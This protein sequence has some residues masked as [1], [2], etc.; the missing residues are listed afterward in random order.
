M[1]KCIKL[2]KLISV[3]TLFSL[4]GAMLFAAPKIRITLASFAPENTVWGRSLNQLA[5]DWSKATNG[6][7]QL[8]VRHNGVLGG[9]ELELI[10][11]IKQGQIQAAILTSVGLNF[12]T[13]KILTLSCPFLIENDGEL[14]YVLNALRPYYE[15]LIKKEGFQIVTLSKLGWIKFFGRDPVY[16]PDD[17]K[18]QKI[19]SANGLTSLNNAFSALG[20]TV[21][22]VSY[23]DIISSL[24]SRRIDAVFNIPVYVAAN[25]IFG[26]TK[27][28][29]SLSVAPALGGIV[30]NQWYWNHIPDKYKPKLL[31]LCQKLQTQN[32]GD[33][34]K[35]ENDAINT[36]KQYGLVVDELSPQQKETW[37]KLV[38]DNMGRLTSGSN[39]VVDEALY[40][41]I[42]GLIQE[43]NSKNPK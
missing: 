10:Q 13:N 28:M 14:D 1:K 17:L 38:E 42:E 9:D 29:C 15:D 20:F 35:L 23:N 41:R 4:D 24:N 19:A 21:E 33:I 5:A 18:K 31:E 12:I 26:I 22:I 3:L 34:S 11:K 6:E 39:P 43:Y 16:T 25:Q 27:N 40:K 8:I 37:H 32:D 36:M 7:V 2:I 30:I